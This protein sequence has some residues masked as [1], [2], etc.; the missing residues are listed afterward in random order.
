PLIEAE[1]LRAA[2]RPVERVVV[3]HPGHPTGAPPGRVQ[4]P[5]QVPSVERPA[6]QL[7]AHLLV[8]A[9]SRIEDPLLPRPLDGAGEPAVDVAR[10]EEGQA[11]L[12]VDYHTEVM[13]LQ[14]VGAG[15]RLGAADAG[16]VR[17]LVR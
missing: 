15:S 6:I 5:H 7:I 8:A 13:I 4:P 2:I 10:G 17:L 9:D 3:G 12:A 11:P 16:G 1:M 14:L